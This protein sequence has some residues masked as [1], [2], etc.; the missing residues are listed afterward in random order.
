MVSNCAGNANTWYQTWCPHCS[1]E[2]WFND[3]D[4]SDCTACSLAG[5]PLKCRKCGK[6]FWLG[7]DEDRE[8]LDLNDP[9]NLGETGKLMREVDNGK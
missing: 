7:E 4:A 1:A 6:G 3:G 2:N 8:E 5:D 9:D